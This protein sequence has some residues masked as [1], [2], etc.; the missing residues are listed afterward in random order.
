MNQH[1]FQQVNQLFT[2]WMDLP[3]EEQ[4][5]RLAQQRQEQSLSDE[6]LSL[7][8]SKLAA[9]QQDSL[10]KDVG[11]LQADWGNVDEELPI[12]QQLGHYRLLKS[13]G[14]GGM[15]QVYLAERADGSFDKQV[16]IKLSMS[17]FNDSLIRRF[18]NE[19]Q[20]LAKLNHP[21]IAQ[22][23]DGGSASDGRPFLVM[24]YV[25]GRNIA[26][27]CIQ[28]RL[29]LKA[30]LQLI[31]QVCAAVSFAHQQ[32]ILHRD[33]KPN[34]ILVDEQGQVKLLDF[35]IAKL[36]KEDVA[37]MTQTATQ[38]MTRSYASPEQLK[39]EVVTT[40]SD[41]FSLALVAYE[42]VTGYHPFPHQSGI[43]RDQKVVSGQFRKISKATGQ[44][45]AVFPQ[46]SDIASEKLAGDLENI[47]TKALS[48]DVRQRYASVELLAADLRNFIANKPITARKPTLGY[49][50]LKWVQ[51][52][53]TVAALLILTSA[54]LVTASVYSYN[55]AVFAEQQALRAEK[56]AGKANA[57]ADFLSQMIVKANPSFNQKEV[58]ARDLLLQGFN[59]INDATDMDAETRFD[60]LSKMYLS[61]WNLGYYDI[62]LETVVDH[63]QTCAA[64]LTL[65]HRYCQK[66]LVGQ[67]DYY[68][69]SG[70][71]EQALTILTQAEDIELNR[72]EPDVDQLLYI[73]D[74]KL[75][76]LLNLEHKDEG[77]AY[78]EKS[79]ALRKLHKADD[80]YAVRGSMNNLALTYIQHQ[81]FAEAEQLIKDIPAYIE[82]LPESGRKYS[83]MGSYY[84]L[85]AYFYQRQ[86]DSIRAAE[87]RQQA[88]EIYNTHFEVLADDR[89]WTERVL[90]SEYAKAGEV[91]KSLIQYARAEQMYRQQGSNPG[92]RLLRIYLE[93]AI[94]YGLTR[95]WQALSREW[96][97]LQS[98]VADQSLNHSHRFKL[99][100]AEALYAQ[101]QFQATEP[102]LRKLSALREHM[103]P[104]APEDDIFRVYLQLAEARQL[105]HQGQR[106]RAISA[107]H[108]ILNFWQKYPRYFLNVRQAVFND[109]A[110]IE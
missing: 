96:S 35:G 39:G 10:P 57:V 84:E 1:D 21:N 66:L 106:D 89:I 90:A 108:E 80:P 75:L 81:R 43:E 109:L 53:K 82:Q 26:D 73:Y 62:S 40:A 68:T 28:H 51:R 64:E 99:A 61:L 33:L 44:T 54:S 11:E 42:L 104:D 107:Y 74:A 105:V 31:L 100:F 4:Q 14:A 79:L 34:N 102:A 77:L 98:M 45:K 93:R 95:D 103:K 83:A 6:Q 25:N 37:G 97:E 12:D 30:R 22:L 13:I 55:R 27:H 15:G 88:A 65:A 49:R 56:E 32:L 86:H 48:P 47:L 46:L 72:M 87:F 63:H 69:R 60:L 24:E 59:D 18:E 91:E 58:T 110:L 20:I 92:V 78:G 71:Y 23:L 8:N 29:G 3:A 5:R 19:R 9:D 7:L 85:L 16:A 70:S 101:H 67:F 38:I 41:V 50:L 2:E 17:H 94:I 36:L 76:T 52:E